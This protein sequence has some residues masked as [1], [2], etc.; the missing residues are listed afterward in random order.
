MSL[1]RN[2]E[3][4][5]LADADRHINK[6]ERVVSRQLVEVERL[7]DA[8]FSTALALRTLE[9]FERALAAMQEHRNLI[10]K[11]IKGIDVGAL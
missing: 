2:T 1:D 8:G 4:Q 9:N 3:V 10:I 5:R 7:R 11:T 6:A